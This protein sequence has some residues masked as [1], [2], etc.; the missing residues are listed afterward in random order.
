LKDCLST[1]LRLKVKKLY[2][3]GRHMNTN[4]IYNGM[5]IYFVL[6]VILPPFLGLK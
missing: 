1:L 4:S 3:P 6:E 5:A 2:L